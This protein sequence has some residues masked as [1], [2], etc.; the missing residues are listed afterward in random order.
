[1]TRA[2][3]I[4]CRYKAKLAMWN[5]TGPNGL[6]NCLPRFNS[7]LWIICWLFTKQ[8][9]ETIYTP[10]WRDFRPWHFEYEATEPPWTCSC[11][12]SILS[13]S[14]L[15]DE[16]H[17]W[18]C[19]QECV[20][21]PLRGCLNQWFRVCVSFSD[22]VHHDSSWLGECTFKLLGEGEAVNCITIYLWLLK[23]FQVLIGHGCIP[24][25]EPGIFKPCVS[26]PQCIGPAGEFFVTQTHTPTSTMHVIHPC[27][28][29]SPI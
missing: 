25:N 20:C 13:E 28:C 18:Q 24:A 5:L 21:S 12:P 1:M 3:I 4:S 19:C 16:T 17:I 8:A 15:V 27:L 23:A 14:C 11:K 26:L 9:C 22:L 2:R 7:L 6:S 10:I 29:T